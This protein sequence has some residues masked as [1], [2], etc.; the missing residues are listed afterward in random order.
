MH[1]ILVLILFLS[2]FLSESLSYFRKLLNKQ[3]FEYK[4][5][6]LQLVPS[7]VL[8]LPPRGIAFDAFT[9]L[10]HFQDRIF[11]VEWVDGWYIGSNFYS[12]H[13]FCR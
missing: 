6:D 1:V 10:K 8:L 9:L 2:I 11:N 12:C 4:K 13:G 5:Q 7:R 3:W